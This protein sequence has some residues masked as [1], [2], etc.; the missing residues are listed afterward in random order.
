[1][2]VDE[3]PLPTSSQKSAKKPEEILLEPEV[4][5]ESADSTSLKH[6][7]GGE[8][9]VPIIQELQKL[10]EIQSEKGSGRFY[11]LNYA[12]KLY[13]IHITLLS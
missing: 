10:S 12:K 6:A 1:M 13:F 8:E 4:Q 5:N 3:D 9:Q 11:L 2:D 7:T